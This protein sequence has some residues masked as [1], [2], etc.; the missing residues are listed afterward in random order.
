VPIELHKQ[1]SNVA[2]FI[3]AVV[4]IA[5]AVLLGLVV[6]AAWEQYQTA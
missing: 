2:G 6:V 3:Y 1:H 4:G 5:Y